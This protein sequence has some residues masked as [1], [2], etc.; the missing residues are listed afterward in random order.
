M[1][2]SIIPKS[3]PWS[4]QG[5]FC[6]GVSCA[7][8][9]IAFPQAAALVAFAAGSGRALALPAAAGR[10][11]CP[12][13]QPGLT[14]SSGH[15][16]LRGS[17]PC[18]RK[19]LRCISVL[20]PAQTQLSRI[21]PCAVS[22]AASAPSAGVTPA[23]VL[24]RTPG[25]LTL[26]CPDAAPG[27]AVLDAGGR[28]AGTVTSSDGNCCT[29][30]FTAAA[31]LCGSCVGLGRAGK[32]GADRPARRLHADRRGDRDHPGRGLAGYAGRSPGPR[33]RRTDGLRPADRYRRSARCRIFCAHRLIFCRNSAI[34]NVFEIH[35]MR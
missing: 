32:V 9:S 3:N 16:T 2:D 18:S 19:I 7:A 26:A 4:R 12:Q 10:Q 21:R 8:G 6:L 5:I 25:G 15:G 28:Y 1:I 29:V 30:A 35:D 11:P 24:A 20:Q 33:C 31:G 14:G 22:L 27:A 17:M 34:I 23:R 13:R